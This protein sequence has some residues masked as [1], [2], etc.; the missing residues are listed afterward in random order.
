MLSSSVLQCLIGCLSNDVLTSTLAIATDSHSLSWTKPLPVPL[1]NTINLLSLEFWSLEHVGYSQELSCLACMVFNITRMLWTEQ[2]T[3]V[4]STESWSW[5]SMTVLSSLKN[6]ISISQMV[7][8]GALG[9]KLAT[10]LHNP[11]SSQ[12]FSL[13]LVQNSHA[14]ICE[15][16]PTFARTGTATTCG[17]LCSPRRLPTMCRTPSPPPQ[18]IWLCGI[19]Q[20]QVETV[21]IQRLVTIFCISFDMHSSAHSM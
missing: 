13:C 18:F 3:L 15:V 19:T 11:I 6:M 9:I 20:M 21:S 5:S 4:P 14:E 7:C 17:A 1:N 8:L 2:V 16:T 12:L 10:T